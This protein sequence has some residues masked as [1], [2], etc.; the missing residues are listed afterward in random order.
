VLY[1]AEMFDRQ[2]KTKVNVETIWLRE[3]MG[4]DGYCVCGKDPAAVNIGVEI[5]WVT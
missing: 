2:G 1:D 4:K 5:G 3:S